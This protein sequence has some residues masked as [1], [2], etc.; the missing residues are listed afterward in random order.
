MAYV[1]RPWLVAA[2]AP[3]AGRVACLCRTIEEARAGPI[4]LGAVPFARD[5][6][7]DPT[8]AESWMA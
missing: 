7:D 8:I 3:R 6:D 4:A 1:V 5:P 2:A